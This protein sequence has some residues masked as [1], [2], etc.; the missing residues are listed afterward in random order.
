MSVSSDVSIGTLVV[1]DVVELI[2]VA[3]VEAAAVAVEG[4]ATAVVVFALAVD[5]WLV[6]LANDD[7]GGDGDDFVL[8]CWDVIG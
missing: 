3:V 5:C 1:V 7:D 8:D 2:C 4:V 6:M